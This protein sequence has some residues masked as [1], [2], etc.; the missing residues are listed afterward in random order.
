[1]RCT[2]VCAGLSRAGT[3][4]S[5]RRSASTRDMRS[6]APIDSSRDCDVAALSSTKKGGPRAALSK[7]YGDC[8]LLRRD[9]HLGCGGAHVGVDVLL[10]LDE[11][12]LEHA[13]QLARGVVEGGFVLPG[14]H[15]IKEM[16]L[17]TRY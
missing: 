4:V 3:A 17:D 12:L 14:L 16:R 10:V 15:R 6:S 5:G 7:R 2:S 9:A 13:H 1:M 11:V 8:R